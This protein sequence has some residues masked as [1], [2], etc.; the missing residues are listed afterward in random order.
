MNLIPCDENCVYQTDGYCLLDQPAVV[1]G[2]KQGNSC[3]HF[4]NKNGAPA[5]EAENGAK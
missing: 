2:Q 1:T 4:V 3:V 5:P